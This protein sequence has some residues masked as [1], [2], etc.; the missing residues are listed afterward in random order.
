MQIKLLYVVLNI[1]FSKNIFF[2]TLLL[3]GT[4]QI[5]IFEVL[6]I[7]MLIKIKYPLN[8]LNV[9]IC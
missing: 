6:L 9:S 3:H 5:L 2:H 8:S 1:T 4:N 7:L